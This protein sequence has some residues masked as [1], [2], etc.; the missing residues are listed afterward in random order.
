MPYRTLPAA[1]PEDTPDDRDVRVEELILGGVFVVFGALRVL[2]EIAS[3]RAF[4]VEA[5]I[6]SI[7]VVVGLVIAWRAGRRATSPRAADIRRP[8]R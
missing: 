3:A 1:D 6:A 8:P 7:F 5:T 2:L 4:G